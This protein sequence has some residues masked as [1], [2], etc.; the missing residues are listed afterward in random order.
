M[1]GA[2]PSSRSSPVP[3]SW[4]RTAGGYRRDGTRRGGRR[5]GTS[6]EPDERHSTGDT[7]RPAIGDRGGAVDTAFDDDDLLALS[8]RHP[9]AFAALYRRHAEE[10]LHFFARRT[11]DPEA[12]AE[13][14]AETF[15]E[16]FASRASFRDRGAG[17]GGWLFGIARHQ[18]SRFYRS[19]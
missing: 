1:R 14:T 16:A 4:R 18:L 13:L 11:L 8:L 9:E 12:A 5:V 10:L 15:A 17:A 7:E 6:R 19:G 2:I 3:S